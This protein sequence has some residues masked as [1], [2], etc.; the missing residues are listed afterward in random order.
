MLVLFKNL[1]LSIKTLTAWKVHKNLKINFIHNKNVEQPI[2]MLIDKK[3]NIKLYS[4]TEIFKFLSNEKNEQDY[5]NWIFST[6][7]SKK[8]T[9]RT[10]LMNIFSEEPK[11]INLLIYKILELENKEFADIFEKAKKDLARLEKICNPVKKVQVQKIKKNQNQNQKKTQKK[12]GKKVVEEI[13]PKYISLLDSQNLI[14]FSKNEKKQVSTEKR[15]ILITAALPYVNNEP[16][17]GNLIG[18]VLSGDVYSRYCRIMNYNSIYIC[19][20]DE[21]GTAT[22]IKARKSN[23]SPKEICDF[24]NK[25][26]SEV[27][28]YFNIDFDHFG[29]TSRH[30]HIKIVQEMFNDCYKNDYILKKEIDQLFCS[31]CELFLADRYVNGNCPKCNSDKAKGDQCDD[32]QTTYESTELLNPRCE[33]CDKGVNLKKSK[34]LYLDLEKL[35]P[36]LKEFVEKSKS[37]N[38]WTNN[39]KAITESWFKMGL[40]PRCITRDLKWGVKVPIK[41]YEKK[42]FYV[43][44]DAPIGYISIT[45]EYTDKWEEWWRNPENVELAQFMGKDNVPFHT[46]FFPATQIGSKKKWTTLNNISTTEYLNYEDAKFSKRNN[47]GVFGTDVMD[48]HEIPVF[49]WRFYL[50]SV[51]PENSDSF[52]KW[53]DLQSKNNNML[54]KN[55]GNFIHRILKFVYT[56]MDKKI[57]AVNM[58]LKPEDKELLENIWV[59]FEKYVKFFEIQKL[60]L[61][62]ETILELSSLCNK[63]TQDSQIWTLKGEE[64]NQKMAILV[65]VIRFIGILFEPFMPSFSAKIYFLLNIKREKEHEVILGKLWEKKCKEDIFRLVVP[66]NEINLPVPLVKNIDCI[67]QYVKRFEGKKK[68]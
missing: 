64:K 28:D 20:T 51:R 30:N 50:L 45:S 52:F 31:A 2:D 7:D 62:L 49:V 19:G 41:E 16:H 61:S 60:R 29:R 35:E 22:E 32:C 55:I 37:K 67:E 5:Y 39:S 27:Y 44:F 18:A 43:W 25:I 23:K 63:Y 6:M 15:N 54:N 42:C 34:H 21:Y 9:H 14:R 10:K 3:N 8:N 13:D 36:Q 59:I 1:N 56:K 26:H 33:I 38:Y 12:K 66:G 47:I 24:Y 57:P 58:E 48:L 11:L 4:S 53:K 65:N 40:K 68:E 46:I 17:L